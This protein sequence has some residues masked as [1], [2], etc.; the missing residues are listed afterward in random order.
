MWLKPPAEAEECPPGIWGGELA[1][2][3]DEGAAWPATLDEIDVAP[4]GGNKDALL[5]PAAVTAL[6]ALAASCAERITADD[7]E[8]GVCGGVEGG[9]SRAACTAVAAESDDADG[10]RC[11][12]AAC[13]ACVAMTACDVAMA[14]GSITDASE[15]CHQMRG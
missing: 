13:S 1:G 2:G 4:L 6:A 3:W 11:G 15:L 14:V 5:R 10:L 12:S 8:P 9:G 7:T